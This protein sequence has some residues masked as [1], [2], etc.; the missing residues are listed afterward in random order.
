MLEN[1]L[2][3]DR[4]F[5]AL[6]NQEWCHPWLDVL[7]P[8]WRTK[9][10]WIPLYGCLL[11][12]IIRTYKW[13]TIWILLL[14]GASIA[15]ADQTSSIW[16]KHSVARL[17]PCREPLIMDQ[18]RILVH[19]GTGFSFTSSHACNHFAL[20]MQLFLLFRKQWKPVYWWAWFAWA[21]LVAYG[22]VYVGVHYPLDVVAGALLGMALAT[23]V[24]C[25]GKQLH[26]I[27]KLNQ[28]IH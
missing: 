23:L 5:F 18:V 24:Y 22:Q 26:I 4:A 17:R 3:A 15:L 21:A 10:T 11:L 7:M 6:L 27:A 2:A 12:V 14:I 20:V 19:C 8:I 25:I 1:L 9:T 16:I 28:A 13:K